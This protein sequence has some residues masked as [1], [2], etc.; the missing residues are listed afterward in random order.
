MKM[1]LTEGVERMLESAE[2]EPFLSFNRRNGITTDAFLDI[3]KEIDAFILQFEREIGMKG[4]SKW[5]GERLDEAVKAG[6][7]T[8]EAHLNL[9]YFSMFDIRSETA[10]ILME[11]YEVQRRGLFRRRYAVYDLSALRFLLTRLAH[12]DTHAH[13]LMTEYGRLY[14]DLARKAIERMQERGIRGDV[15][16]KKLPLD[17]SAPIYVREKEEKV[18]RRMQRFAINA[19]LKEKYERGEEKYGILGVPLF[20][21]PDENVASRMKELLGGAVEF[22]AGFLSGYRSVLAAYADSL[23]EKSVE[24][25]YEGARSY[26]HRSE[27][28]LKD[29]VE[30]CLSGDFSPLHARGEMEIVWKPHA[31]RCDPP[32]PK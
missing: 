32:S 6:R 8:V 1:R 17:V 26:L 28:F 15:A 19:F 16:L 29:V 23:R 18:A 13:L 22:K 4:A 3:I 30:R 27:E 20:V 24:E 25:I 21:K 2:E 10:F 12:E 9:S 14:E 31:G 11:N 5:I 7:A